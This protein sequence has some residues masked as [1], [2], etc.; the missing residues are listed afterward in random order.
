MRL[1]SFLFSTIFKKNLATFILT[2]NHHPLASIQHWMEKRNPQKLKINNVPPAHRP[3][4]PHH[5]G[6]RGK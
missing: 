2:N 1:S 4:L 3:C 5:K 6:A